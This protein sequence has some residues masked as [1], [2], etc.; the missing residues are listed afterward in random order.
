MSLPLQSILLL[1]GAV[2]CSAAPVRSGKASVEWISSS[3]STLPGQAVE[4]AI[5]MIIDPG[6][7]G[8]WINPGDAGMKTSVAWQLPPGW[9]ASEP[10]FP[11]PERFVSGGLAGFGYHGTVLL[12]VTLTPPAEFQGTAMLKGELSWLTCNDNGCVPGNAVIH[13]QIVSG[14]PTPAADARTIQSARL[15]IPKNP[16]NLGKSLKLTVTENPKQLLLTIH[17]EDSKDQNINQYEGFPLTPGVVDSSAPIRFT[18]Q[19]GTWQAEVPK[20]EYATSPLREFTLV[21]AARRSENGAG[22]G[23]GTAPPLELEWRAAEPSV[24]PQPTSPE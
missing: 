13:L 16:A 24:P 23:S 15:A 21:L 4:T 10:A 5:R 22:K 19:S 3:A 20:S 2:L 17:S 12:P 18:Q 9:S 11:A 7:H 6:W 8:Y 14:T 1:G